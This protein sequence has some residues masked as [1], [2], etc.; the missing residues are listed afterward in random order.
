M[1]FPT[2]MLALVGGLF[3]IAAP[4]QA[5]V[6]VTNESDAKT[7]VT[8]DHGDVENEHELEPGASIEEAC[9]KGCGV[10]FGGHDFVAQD[11]DQ[12]AIEAGSQRPVKRN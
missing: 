11:G 2:T 1:Q 8:F 5:M 3:L 7:S 10:R 6:T 9:P 4:A 12:L